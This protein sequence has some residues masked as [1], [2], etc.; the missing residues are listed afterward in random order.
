[1][2][3]LTF[4]FLAIFLIVKPATA[5]NSNIDGY[6]PPPLFGASP[7]PAPVIESKPV[8]EPEPT[9]Q[10]IKK[11]E[12]KK[13]QPEQK[14]VVVAPTPK[15]KPY[16]A[17]QVKPVS[18]STELVEEKIKAPVPPAPKV[19]SLKKPE[20]P[21]KTET[22][23]QTA[24]VVKGP[25][26]MPSIKKESV[27][28]E[29]TFETIETELPNIMERAQNTESEEEVSEE[30]KLAA[31]PKATI[32]GFK[33]LED[34]TERMVMYYREAQSDLEPK[35]HTVLS[36]GILPRLKESDNR[37]LIQ[38]FAMPQETGMS[39]DRRLSLTRAL[40]IRRYLLENNVSSSRIDV[41]A[42]GSQSNTQP[43]DRVELILIP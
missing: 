7:A 31:L 34:G 8:P 33:K 6:V 40:A 27:D 3:H 15:K 32:P 14:K 12:T 16:R 20:P 37:L 22:R 26:T 39:S 41:R 13:P 9:V 19:T 21:P 4:L 11:E 38:A 23:P 18:E 24:G 43:L 28:T 35:Q 5:Q 10:K 2:K 17:P 30:E 29:V 25:K 1:M 36:K 42:L